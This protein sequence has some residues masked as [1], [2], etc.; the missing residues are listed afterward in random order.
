MQML[1]Q[2]MHTIMGYPKPMSKAQKNAFVDQNGLAAKYKCLFIQMEDI[3]LQKNQDQGLDLEMEIKLE[4]EVL[5]QNLDQ[6]VKSRN[7]MQK[8]KDNRI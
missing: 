4:A 8:I 7:K 3:G 6:E 5:D 2:E 1:C